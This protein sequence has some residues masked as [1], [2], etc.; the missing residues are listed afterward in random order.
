M[1][2]VFDER[3]HIVGVPV[4]VIRRDA[5]GM[6]ALAVAAMVEENACVPSGQRL[7]VTGRPPEV[8]IASRA[9]MQDEWR[10]RALDLVVKANPVRC[11]KRRQ[12]WLESIPKDKRKGQ[13]PRSGPSAI[14]A[15]VS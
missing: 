5:R 11:Q 10:A 13:T 6:V 15:P 2:Q 8:R 9:K 12:F 7:Q 1:P 14:S 3:C 4:D